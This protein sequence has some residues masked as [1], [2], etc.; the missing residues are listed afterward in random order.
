MSTQPV[1]I[2][3]SIDQLVQALEAHAYIPERSLATAIFLALKLQRPLFLEGEAGVGKTEVAKVLAQL[4]DRPDPPTAVFAASDML[5]LGAMEQIH[6]RGLRVPGDVALVGFDDIELAAFAALT[7]V[8]Q[9]MRRMG[10]LAAQALV[11]LLAKEP[12]E[13]LAQELPLTLVVRESCGAKAGLQSGV[14]PSESTHP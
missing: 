11:Q 1:S 5:A 2:P 13:T 7:T 3:Q 10:R 12:L 4:L 14:A 8:R 9:P 6:Q